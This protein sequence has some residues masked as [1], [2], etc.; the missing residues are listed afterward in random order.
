MEEEGT[1]KCPVCTGGDTVETTSTID[2]NT[3]KKVGVGSLLGGIAMVVG[4]GFLVAVGVAACRDPVVSS[5]SGN[6]LTVAGVGALLFFTG[7]PM[8]ATFLKRKRVEL[9]SFACNSCQNSWNRLGGEDDTSA[10]DAI[11]EA[12][13][14]ENPNVRAEAAAVLANV[15]DS[16]ALEPL[17]H[18]AGDD[19]EDVRSAAVRAL[20]GIWD[21]RAVDAIL[22][23][24]EEESKHVRAAAAAALGSHRDPRI[25]EPLIAA[26]KDKSWTV[27]SEAGS[28]LKKITGETLVSQQ[29]AQ[30]WWDQNKET[31]G[32]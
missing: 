25:I 29:V 32:K 16:R 14:N 23:A 3:G 18:A 19:V 9:T 11:V 2:R 30:M 6:P 15:K 21:G 20:G 8:I 4:G 17:L 27:Q 24:L 12:L 5:G 7:L 10:L 28:A 26:L 31:F 1:M 22:G 13:R